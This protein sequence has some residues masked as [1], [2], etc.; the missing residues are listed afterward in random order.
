MNCICFGH[1]VTLLAFERKE[2][3]INLPIGFVLKSKV[4][5]ILKGSIFC[6]YIIC[7]SMYFVYEA[8]VLSR[9]I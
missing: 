1:F 8:F 5:N 3:S 4:V 6:V 9:N 7:E 2:N